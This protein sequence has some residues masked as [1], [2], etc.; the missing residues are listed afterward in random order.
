MRC[1]ATRLVGIWAVFGFARVV[2]Y[3]EPFPPSGIDLAGDLDRPVVDKL[4][5]FGIRLGDAGWNGAVA[6]QIDD[7]SRIAVNFKTGDVTVFD[8]KGVVTHRGKIAFDLSDPLRINW[9]GQINDAPANGFLVADNEPNSV[10]LQASV[11]GT[12]SRFRWQLSAG[13]EGIVN[14]KDISSVRTVRSLWGQ[15]YQVG[16]RLTGKKA[17][18][19]LTVRLKDGSSIAYNVPSGDFTFFAPDGAV[20]HAG[21]IKLD[22]SHPSRIYLQGTI[23]ADAVTGFLVPMNKEGL[24]LYQAVVESVYRRGLIRLRGI[25]EDE[26]TLAESVAAVIC[27]CWPEVGAGGCTEAD[28]NT[29]ETC[30]TGSVC[31]WR[32]NGT[33]GPIAIGLTAILLGLSAAEIR[34]RRRLSAFQEG[35]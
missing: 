1:T 34:D 12:L 10:L 15:L 7:G 9:Q 28:C 4:T 21:S 31:M 25:A 6:F 32:H 19:D 20:A 3:G 27:T 30:G 26:A 8:P 17:K 16:F 33:A 13:N 14:C 2:T 23:D 22:I 24:L 29:S 18:D 5:D 11:E 35:Q